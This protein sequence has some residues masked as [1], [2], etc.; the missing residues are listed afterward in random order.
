MIIHPKVRGFICTTA[1]PEGCFRE[2][3]AQVEFI[4]AHGKFSGPKNVLVIG[5][6]T[7]Y[8]LASRIATA[9]GA[10]AKTIGVA[11][12]RPADEKRTATAGWYNTA[13][14]EDLAHRDHLYAKS[15]NGDAFSNEIKRQTL[16][17]IRKDLGQVDLV[18]YSLAS[19]R[20]VHP[21]TGHIYSSVL[22]PIGQTFTSKTVEPFKGDVKQITIEPANEQEIA[23]TIEVMGGEDWQMWIDALKNEQLLAQ[24]AVTVAYTYIGP[25]LTHSIYKNGT[26]GKAKDHLFQTGQR[27]DESLASLNGHAYISVNK[28]LVTQASA[29][30]PVVPLYI[31]LLFKLMKA[32]GTHEG[33]IEQINRLYKE[34]LYGSLSLDNQGMISIDD[35]EMTDEIQKEIMRL[36][37]V[38]TTENLSSLTD[39]E[40]YR[41]DFYR[42]FGF[43]N[44]N[45]DYDQDVNPHVKIASIQNEAAV[46]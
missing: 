24:N 14:F 5:A 38:V 19:P 27:I 17:L 29:A 34:R 20:R 31:A 36:W 1:H 26:I 7:G 30:I 23:D 33:C 8:G 35:W 22:K 10:Q 21:D 18:V 6:S 40:G 42:L 37:P 3:Q 15:I 11:F 44:P 39:I 45:I 41:H 16:D 13:A 25:E 28:A 12:E 46:C 32:Q 2:V 9:F 4:K 43:S